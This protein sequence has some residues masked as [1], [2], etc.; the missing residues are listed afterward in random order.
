[1]DAPNHH[2]D[3]FEW[4]Q[5]QSAA[6]RSHPLDCDELDVE[7]LAEEIEDMGLEQIRKTSS[8]LVQML[9]HLFKLHLE[10]NAPSAQHWFEEVLRF[11]ADAVLAFSPGIK[12]RLDLDKIWKL[13]RKGATSTV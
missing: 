6:L 7:H 12:R 3:F 5:Q 8:F 1:M 2:S 11:Q 9:V 10:P 4:T 13:A